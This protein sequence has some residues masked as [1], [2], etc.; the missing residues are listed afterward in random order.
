VSDSLDVEVA[1]D[2]DVFV[3]VSH[4]D[5]DHELQPSVD[6]DEASALGLLCCDL[7]GIL[8]SK[9]AYFVLMF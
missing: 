9:V 8:N 4:D 6:Q 3:P 1:S 2:S 7:I 5:I